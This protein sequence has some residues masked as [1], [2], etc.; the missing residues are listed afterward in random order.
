MNTNGALV[1]F[2][3]SNVIQP[4]GNNSDITPE[5]T[6]TILRLTSVSH[7][8]LT[9]MAKRHRQDADMRTLSDVSVL[10]KDAH[11]DGKSK[12]KSKIYKHT[13]G[14]NRRQ[15]CCF[16][17]NRV[18]LATNLANHS[19]KL[20]RGLPCC[21]ERKIREMECQKAE[22][23]ENAERI[24]LA[25]RRLFSQEFGS[26]QSEHFDTN[27]VGLTTSSDSSSVRMANEMGNT[28]KHFNDEQL[29][30]VEKGLFV[31]WTSH[32]EIPTR[33]LG[34]RVCL[35]KLTK[36]VR[37][38]LLHFV[39]WCCQR[40]HTP[41]TAAMASMHRIWI[42]RLVQFIWPNYSEI[43]GSDILIFGVTLFLKHD[44]LSQFFR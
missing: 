11:W 38:S 25:N 33:C 42:G 12:P 9:R 17:C 3:R 30:H 7:D 31:K 39:R 27:Y 43:T 16:R 26:S 44:T 37:L 35:P 5:S 28:V 8:A 24:D 6:S 23:N 19:M 40:S 29:K 41:S 13:V 15:K 34:T 14:L 10:S 2:N 4:D 36:P 1:I 20:H 32:I 22:E 18:V 21:A